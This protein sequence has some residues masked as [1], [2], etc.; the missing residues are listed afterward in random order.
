MTCYVDGYLKPKVTSKD[1]CLAKSSSG[2]R[3]SS[4]RLAI[5]RLEV[6]VSGD[7]AIREECSKYGREE[8]DCVEYYYQ[9]GSGGDGVSSGGG[10]AGLGQSQHRPPPRRMCP[11]P[12]FRWI[13]RY[14]RRRC[15]RNSRR[16]SN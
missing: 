15:V 6:L 7:W 1:V 2:R 11:E 10:T 5:Y 9:A 14:G 3:R 16:R 13:R 12:R 8:A 4:S